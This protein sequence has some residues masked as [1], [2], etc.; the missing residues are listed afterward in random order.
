MIYGHNIGMVVMM[1]N[2]KIFFH[3]TSG[4]YMPRNEVY[5]GY[6]NTLTAIKRGDDII[7]TTQLALMTFEDTVGYDMYLLMDFSLHYIEHPIIKLEP[8]M[9]FG[10]GNIKMFSSSLL[11][12]FKQ[13][14]FFDKIFTYSIKNKYHNIGEIYE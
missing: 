13:G 14:L 4:L 7:H 1:N 6:S 8:D 3:E 5:T 12:L 2:K 10:T 9:P 11:N